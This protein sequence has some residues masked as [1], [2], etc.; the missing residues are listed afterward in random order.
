MQD[1]LIRWRG[2]RSSERGRFRINQDVA[3]VRRA[4]RER[5]AVVEDILGLALRHLELALERAGVLPELFDLLLLL[6][7][8]RLVVRHGQL[9]FRHGGPG[10]CSAAVGVLSLGVPRGGRQRESAAREDQQ[11]EHDVV[12]GF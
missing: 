1:H 4:G 6:R 12:C 11:K 2:L 8:L 5:R 7:E 9:V 10:G 3:V